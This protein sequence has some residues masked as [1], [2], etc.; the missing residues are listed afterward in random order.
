MRKTASILLGVSTATLLLGSL[1]TA[2]VAGAQGSAPSAK[3]CGDKENP[4]K[5]VVTQGGCIAIERTKGNCHSCHVVKGINYGNVAPPLVSM[6]ARFPDKA[7]LRDQVSDASKANPKTVM[8][9]FGRHGI[10]SED[11]IDKV[12]EWLLTL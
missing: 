1:F 7:K 10:L 11:E 12:V 6:K 4:P 2:P 5:D 3:V 9:P 8:P